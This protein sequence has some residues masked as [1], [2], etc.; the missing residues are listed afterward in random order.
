MSFSRK[1]NSALL[2]AAI[3]LAGAFSV[4]AQ[5]NYTIAEVQ[6]DKA[7]SPHEREKVRISGVVTAVLKKGFYIQTPDDKVDDNPKTSEGIYVYGEQSAGQVALRDLVQVEGTVAEFRPRTERIF[8]S[9]T[10]I[11]QPTVKVLSKDN[12]MPSAVTL[13]TADLDPRGKLDQMERFEGMRVRADLVVVGPTGGFTNVKTG[14]TTSNGVFFATLQGVPRPF[15]EPGVD[16]LTAYVDKL[17]DTVPRF[18]MNPEIL[19]IDSLSQVDAKPLDLTTGVTMKGVTGVIDY[20]KKFYTLVMDA[21]G[22]PEPENMRTFFPVKAAGARELTVGSFNIENF[23]DDE[24]N[25]SNVKNETVLPKDV[26]QARLKKVSLAIRNV[27]A[28]PD[29]L[30]IVEVENIKV[31]KKVA[32]QVNADAVAAGQPDPKYVAYLEEGNDVR[33]IDVGFLVKSGKVKVVETKQLGAKEKLGS[34]A[35]DP[36]DVLYDRPPL[37][38]RAEA[39]DPE[40]SKPLAVT[41]IV[42]HFKSYR[43]IDDVKDGERVQ[44]KRRLEAEWLANYIQDRQ[45]ADPNE[46][47]IVCGDLNAFQFNDGYNDLIGILKGRSDQN[48]LTPSRTA[49]TTNLADLVDFISQE[50]RYSYVYDGSAQ[51]LD[52]ILVNKPVRE[53]S[54]KFGFAR[55]DADFPL[56]WSNDATRPERVSDHDAPV[57]FISFDAAKPTPVKPQ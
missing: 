33:G 14:I 29:I 12:P 44:N 16:V 8:L 21:A 53:H 4:L 3:I 54:L 27:L 48:V 46:N 11:T 34:Y 56:V 51:A 50:N 15:R 43:G 52:H 20:S 22:R 42:N 57:V 41:V 9:I 38:L 39:A 45:K 19:R 47:I 18:D 26:F 17:A 28:M 35:N 25:S 1:F 23:F 10:E 31:L 30:G 2:G 32:D 5:T 40:S 55:V 37:M 13:T 6:G 24:V 7:V 49:F 36:N